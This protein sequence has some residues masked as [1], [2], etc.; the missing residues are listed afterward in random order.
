[1][2][3]RHRREHDNTHPVTKEPL[4]PKDLITLNYSRNASGELND[5]VTF[6]LF[7]EHSH[8]VAI[9]TSGNVYLSESVKLFA[10]SGKD[11]VSDVDFK[12]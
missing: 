8:I 11:P 7:S 3:T 1:M 5:P 9:A 2:L 4:L 12:K 10:A 6:K